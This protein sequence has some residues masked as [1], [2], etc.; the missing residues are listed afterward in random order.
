MSYVTTNYQLASGHDNAGSLTA[1]TSL[2]VSN[3]AFVEPQGIPFVNRGRR[4]ILAN[5]VTNRT[6][7]PRTDWVS[8]LLYT[9]WQYLVDNY[10][11]LVTVKL[12]LDGATWSN[13][14]GVLTLQ[15]PAEMEYV[16]FAAAS[17]DVDFVGPGFRNARWSFTQLVAL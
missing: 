3:V 17:H 5:G 12:A 1:V 13:Y 2:S 14:N 11:G 6:G 7:K 8:D 15:D 9:Q 16:V 10:E 4:I